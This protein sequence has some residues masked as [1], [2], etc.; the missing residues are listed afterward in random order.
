MSQ[1][2]YHPEL[3]VYHRSLELE[4]D[5]LILFEQLYYNDDEAVY[6]ESLLPDHTHGRYT[7]MGA[8]PLARL[9]TNKEC[10]Q[11]RTGDDGI[12]YQGKQL[13]EALRLLKKGAPAHPAI[14]P[15]SGGALGFMAYDAIR[16][17]EKLPDANPDPYDI[18]DAHFIVPAEVLVVD[19]HKA[20]VDVIIYCVVGG[21]K[22]LDALEEQIRQISKSV[23]AANEKECESVEVHG[24]GRDDYCKIVN[25]C[26]EYILAGDV[27]QVVPSQRLTFTA[28]VPAM[29]Y[30]RSLR[31]V[32]P[33]PYMFIIKL[34][35]LCVLGSSP[36]VLVRCE[37][38]KAETRPLAGTRPRGS[39]IEK[40]DALAHELI[41]DEKE[42]AEHLMLIDLARS[43]LGRVCVPGTVRTPRFMEIDRF[44]KV[45]HM[46]SRVEGEL[47][48]QK[49][50]WDLVAATFPA[51]T[52]SGSPKIRAM[53]IIDELEPVRRGIYAGAVGFADWSGDLELSIAIRTLVLKGNH[54]LLQAGA[55]IVADSDPDKE[56]DE[57]INKARALLDAIGAGDSI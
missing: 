23:P 57:T 8:R 18:P 30:Y 50:E 26:K 53:E 14:K 46:V 12:V 6:L 36:E 34:Y 10:I 54:G 38:G 48:P 51:G 11:I 13:F 47:S 19:H 33:S 40:D 32:N 45:M 16:Y 37:N 1:N 28:Q 41:T 44:A 7:L 21:E 4:C 43:D 22:R 55:G 56:Y 52:V 20:V 31:K 24:P 5:P 42:K 49:D 3:K 25:A 2:I 17:V 29:N 35:D 27:F 39:T 9:I 15:F